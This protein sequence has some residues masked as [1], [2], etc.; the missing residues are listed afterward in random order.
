MI[1]KALQYFE[2]FNAN[3]RELYPQTVPN[4]KAPA[5]LCEQI[6]FLDC[7]DAELEKTYYFRW[8][9]LRKHIRLTPEGYIFTEFL[10]PVK[11]AGAYNSIVCPACFHSRESRWMKDSDVYT[12]QCLQFWLD[13]KGDS[14]KYSSWLCH[15]VWEYCSLN[16][17]FSFAARN[18]SKMVRFFRAREE[19]Q[20]RSC[21]LYW[22]NDGRDGMEYSVSGS[23]LRPTL[24]SYVYADARAIAQTAALAGDDALAR[25]FDEIADTLREKTDTLLWDGEFYRVIPLAETDDP[26]LTARPSVVPEH[27]VRELLG[28]I[29]WYF[30]MP[31]AEKSAA[32]SHLLSDFSAPY[33]LTT[34]EKTHPRFMES[35][36]H[37][38]LWNGP[39]WPF[40]TSQ[41]LVAVAELLRG[42]K[43]NVLDSND[44]YRLLSQY[45]RAHRIHAEDGR[46]LP[47]ID[48]SLDPFS[49]K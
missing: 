5:F 33:G 27:D 16:G 38:C 26:R 39:S 40:A 42:S 21:G 8:W 34:A 46:I 1:Q 41:T 44:Y 6:P 37:E 23:G 43:Q 17:D 11:W 9:T 35:H 4:A 28:Y 14:L 2:E 24:N 30:G 29:P 13:G 25:E 49:G 47:W 20:R 15:A 12:A 31:S 18:L 45:A 7:P 32:F 22:S 19:K 36:E 48:E 3:D 10:P